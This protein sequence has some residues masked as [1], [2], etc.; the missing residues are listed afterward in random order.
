MR[1]WRKALRFAFAGLAYLL[2]T[3]RN[4][5]IH[6]VV[7]VIVIVLGAWLRLD[8]HDWCWLVVAMTGVWSMEAVNT[9]L[10]CL[11]DF[12]TSEHCPLI[13]HAKDAGAAAVLCAAAGAS[14]IG[15]LVLGPPLWAA[16]AK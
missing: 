15:L 10:E 6:A 14:V 11:G 4:A 8:A 16:V 2:R 9:A 13:G 3:Q 1:K 12:V 7:S 5:R